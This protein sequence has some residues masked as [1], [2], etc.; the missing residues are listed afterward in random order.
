MAYS[1]AEVKSGALIIVSFALLLGLTFWVG[2]FTGGETQSYHIR[3]G[4]ISGLERNAPVYFGG[5]EVGKVS[6]IRIHRGEERP[7]VVTV[8]VPLEI[9]I[10][11]GDQ[12]FIDMLGMM[13]EKI[14]EIRPSAAA[15]KILSSGGQLE[16]TDPIPMY[17]LIQKMDLL[18]DRMDE[19]TTSLNPMMTQLESLLSGHEEEIAR[20]IANFEETSANIRDMTGDLKFRPWRLLRKG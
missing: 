2:N 10:R 8:S 6:S 11:E 20:M 9:E 7:I 15:T 3:F 5:H 19:L 12:A 13:G 1:T 16:G 17:R 4:Y 14:I 18:A